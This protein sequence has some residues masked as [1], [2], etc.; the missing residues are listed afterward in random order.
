MAR[1]HEQYGPDL[2]LNMLSSLVRGAKVYSPLS[3]FLSTFFTSIGSARFRSL[4]V[5]DSSRTDVTTGLE[6]IMYASSIVMASCAT[7][8][9]AR[10]QFRL[11]EKVSVAASLQNFAKL[12]SPHAPRIER[13]GRPLIYAG[14]KLCNFGQH[15]DCGRAG[16][17][18]YCTETALSLLK[19]TRGE[20][21]R[22]YL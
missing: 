7:E 19:T 18:F 1:R 2:L 17:L 4:V 6:Q 15:Q 21:K 11:P 13:D 12:A 20:K 22:R 14:N 9:S 10:R 16:K 8:S 5:A 3:S